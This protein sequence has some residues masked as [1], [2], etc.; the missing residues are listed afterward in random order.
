MTQIIELA[1]K[2]VN[3][4][5]VFQILNKLWRVMKDRK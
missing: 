3:T 4:V 5:T 2:D 1:S